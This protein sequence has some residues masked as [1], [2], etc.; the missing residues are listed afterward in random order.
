MGQNILGYGLKSLA[1]PST[2]VTLQG[3]QYSVLPSGQY[4]VMPGKYTFLQWYDPV[5]LTWKNFQTPTQSGPYVLSSDGYNYRLA[6]MTGCVVGAVVT[7]GGTANTAKNGIYPAATSNST[8]GVVATTTTPTNGVAATFNAIVGG[9]VST[10]VTVATAGSGYVLPPIVTFSLPPAGGLQATGY[11]TLNSSG[12]VTSVTVKNQ[13]AGYTSAPT[14]TLTAV[15]GDL[16]T[17]ATATA[18]LDTTTN[19][20]KLVAL[21]MATNGELYTAVPTITIAG[22]AGSP[23]A[24]AIMCFAITTVATPSGATHYGNGN[25]LSFAGA[26]TGGANTTTNPDYTTGIF[27]PR[28][29]YCAYSTSATLATPTLIDAGLQQVDASNQ[30]VVAWASDGTIPGATTF[31]S[32]ASGAITDQSFVIPI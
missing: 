5:S 31:A 3:G 23:A 32:G 13:G 29:A 11:A 28:M 2:A 26:V 12:G 8:S 1:N 7:N 22:L 10:T 15:P 4:M 16:G 18:V 20:G 24:T 27:A 19:T 9:V 25:V 14:V 6:N 17:G 21:T 30:G